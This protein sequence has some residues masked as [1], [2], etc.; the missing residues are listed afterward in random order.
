MIV[1]LQ[2][3][4]AMAPP[5]HPHHRHHHHFVENQL[6]ND[7]EPTVQLASNDWQDL[8]GAPTE[9][10]NGQMAVTALTVDENNAQL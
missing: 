4:V 9:E 3:C 8:S 7:A 2:S 1:M 10:E 5:R 6:T